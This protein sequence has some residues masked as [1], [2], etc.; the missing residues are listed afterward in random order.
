MAEGGE[1]RVGDVEI[2]YDV[3]EFESLV[4]RARLLPAGD[5]RTE[6]LWQRAVDLYQG[7]FLVD[8]ARSWC[9]ARRESLRDAYIEALMGLARG[10][11][12][13]R[14]PDR[15]V[16]WYRQALA[17]DELREDVHRRLIRCFEATGR[18]SDALGQYARCRDVL[19]DELGVEPEEETQALYRRIAGKGAD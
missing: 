2:W 17:V 12:A 5:W 14:N 10:C 13:R 4:E 3:A 9:V 7:D 19:R 8:V 16:D 11:E 1:Y 6:D 18:R 15:A